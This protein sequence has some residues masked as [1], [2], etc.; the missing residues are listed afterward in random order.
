MNAFDRQRERAWLCAAGFGRQLASDLCFPSM[1]SITS[2]SS[3]RHVGLELIILANDFRSWIARR[4]ERLE[5]VNSAVVRR[6]VR[7]DIDLGVILESEYKPESHPLW[8]GYVLVPIG[9]LTRGLHATLEVVREDGSQ[10]P[11]LTKHEERSLVLEGLID[12]HLG[13]R[14]RATLNPQYLEVLQSL[15]FQEPVEDVIHSHQGVSQT[16]LAD[17]NLLSAVRMVNRNYFLVVPLPPDGPSRRVVTYSSLEQIPSASPGSRDRMG[18]RSIPVEVPGAGDCR[19]YHF[20]L[21]APPALLVRDAEL[22]LVAAE[23]QA[24]PRIYHDV[25]RLE[26]HAHLYVEDAGRLMSAKFSAKLV[27]SRHG[28]FEQHCWQ[29]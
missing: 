27:A 24:Q 1:V 19:S 18:E 9:V 29:V 21:V 6:T 2:E 13:G 20:E 8:K 17:S 26:S 23:R 14:Q 25:D 10:I 22:R 4:E 16:L 11:R 12:L 3:Y 7:V 5:F 28:W 15:V